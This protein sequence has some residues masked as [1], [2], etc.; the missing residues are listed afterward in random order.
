MGEV[1]FTMPS[2]E[3]VVKCIVDKKCVTDNC[4]PKLLTKKDIKKIENSEELLA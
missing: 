4:A 2:Q 3:N 1:M